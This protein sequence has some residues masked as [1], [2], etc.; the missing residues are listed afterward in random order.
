MSQFY[1]KYIETSFGERKQAEFKFDQFNIN[2]RSYFP[3]DKEA[4]ILDIGPGR[5]EM[6][7]C[8]QRWG[9]QNYLGI[10]ISPDVIEFC[11]SL[12]YKCELV[13]D[14]VLWLKEHKE[15]FDLITLLDVLEHIPR[16]QTLTF[17]AAVKDSL[18]I[19]GTLII[20]VPNLESPEGYLTHFADFTHEVG[21]TEH[22]MR[23]VLAM[24]GFTNFTIKG[25]EGYIMNNWKKYLARFLRGIYWKGIRFS[26]MIS[27]N[28]VPNIMDTVFF[29]VIR[30]NK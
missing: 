19:G 21:F 23:Q 20:Q 16:S 4:R 2:Y 1:D 24:S 25:F 28:L 7:E 8:I 5:G 3:A 26:R 30:K 29:A 9:Y 22:S 13:P 12:N 27:N 11:R 6:L 10:D 14:T 15:S 17:L 18:R